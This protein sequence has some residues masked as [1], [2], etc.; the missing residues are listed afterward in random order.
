M[1]AAVNS[2]M[3]D[4]LAV[5]ARKDY[6]DRR[7]RQA[8]RQAKAKAEGRGPISWSP[9]GYQ[10]ECRD[11]LHADQGRFVVADLG[12]RVF[13]RGDG[14]QHW[15]ILCPRWFEWPKGRGE[16]FRPLAVSSPW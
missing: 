16:D 15:A 3:L 4:V 7:R 9:G 6:E 10:A 14:A 1:F 8:Q 11:C 13:R 5:V 2:M 12:C